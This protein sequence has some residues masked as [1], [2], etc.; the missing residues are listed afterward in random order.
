MDVFKGALKDSLKGSTAW[1]FRAQ[2]NKALI[3]IPFLIMLC[4]E[5]GKP[6]QLNNTISS[7]WIQKI[8]TFQ[9]IGQ[10]D[11]KMNK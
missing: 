1:D 3:K 9:S 4:L 11:K 8:S 10:N 2:H 7:Y 5:E 6:F